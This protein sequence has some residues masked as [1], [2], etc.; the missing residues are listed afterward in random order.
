MLA[1]HIWKYRN[2]ARLPDSVRQNKRCVNKH[3]SVQDLFSLSPWKNSP[4]EAAQT[5]RRTLKCTESQFLRQHGCGVVMT[6]ESRWCCG[7][8]DEVLEFYFYWLEKERWPPSVSTM[9]AA[10][11]VAKKLGEEFCVKLTLEQ[12]VWTKSQTPTRSIKNTDWE[13]HLKTN[14]FCIFNF[15]FV[16]RTRHNS[17][18][19]HAFYC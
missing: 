11:G 1:A 8:S 7:L 4:R 2:A 17:F 15:R 18:S 3:F 19:V 5:K 12:W 9:I 16:E 10:T 13:H 6:H 14:P